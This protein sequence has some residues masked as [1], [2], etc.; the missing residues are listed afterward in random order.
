M[1]SKLETMG[2]STGRSRTSLTTIRSSK[3]LKLTGDSELTKTLGIGT[4][5]ETLVSWHQV[6]RTRDCLRLTLTL[7]FWHWVEGL[8]HESKMNNR[9]VGMWDCA[10]QVNRHFLG[11]SP[12]RSSRDILLLL[13]PYSVRAKWE[14]WLLHGPRVFIFWPIGPATEATICRSS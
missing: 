4:L 8:V 3:A 7:R 12:V 13:L 14:F 2:W 11:F 6:T 5:S 10:S 1:E 9:R